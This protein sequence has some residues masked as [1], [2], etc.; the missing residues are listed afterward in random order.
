MLRKPQ[1][2][3]VEEL[4]PEILEE[5]LSLLAKLTPDEWNRP[6][7]C[8]G[9]SV[10]DVALHLLGVEIGNL[11]R[12]RD[13]QVEPGAPISNWSELVAVLKDWN[14]SWVESARRMSASV[15]IDLLGL[16]GRQWC[17]YV[18]SLDPFEIGRPV[19]W[20]GPQP[21]PVWLDLAREY[22]ER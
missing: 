5:L 16:T 11:S 2:I 21:V 10:K 8:P 4:F 18:R 20:V 14:E 12:R 19:S 13:E 7:V 15:L 22:T 17:V 1:P 9:W 3:L 6:T